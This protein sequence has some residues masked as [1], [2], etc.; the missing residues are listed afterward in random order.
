MKYS[1]FNTF[2][3]LSLFLVATFASSAKPVELVI[4]QVPN[5]PKMEE[6]IGGLLESYEKENNVKVNVQVLPWNELDVMWT[7][8]FQS[9][10][11]PSFGYTYDTVLPNYMRMGGLEPLEKY[12]TQEELSKI[13]EE[14]L[15]SCYYQGH[16]YAIPSLVTTNPLMYNI[17][18]FAKAGI[19]IPD[20]PYYSPAWEEFLNWCRKLKSAGYG[21][22][23]IGLR[24]VWDHPMDDFIM[25][26]GAKLTN[27]DNTKM[28]FNSP[29]GLRVARA[30]RDIAP[31]LTDK[32]RSVAWNY[33]DEFFT[34]KTAMMEQGGW[35]SQR[36]IKDY[37]DINWGVMLPFHQKEHKAYLGIGYYAVF[38]GAKNKEEVIKL[39]KY[40]TFTDV[41]S[42]WNAEIGAYPPIKG[43]G[44]NMYKNVPEKHKQVLDLMLNLLE[45]GKAKYFSV[46][47]GFTRFADEVF[48]PNWQALMLDRIS[49]EAFVKKVDEGGNRIL[50]E[51]SSK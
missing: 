15:R 14:P 44:K 17:D 43:A 37:P 2:L 6:L 22:F 26:F 32:A 18:L 20:D 1:K 23:D 28:A 4:W 29:E 19:K 39:L 33:A 24:E 42:S 48:L 36:L 49:P 41:A 30:W 16:L 40:M 8:A 10:E 45:S 3:I 11:T 27:K 47:P 9:G 38:K 51:E 5:H 21:S 50:K 35:M 25:R 12:F 46:W 34:G 7:S 31:T 13:M